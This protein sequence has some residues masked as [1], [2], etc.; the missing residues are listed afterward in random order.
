VNRPIGIDFLAEGRRPRLGVALL[1]AGALCAAL[2]G[3]RFA[4][5]HTEIASLGDR[6]TAR[7][8]PREDLKRVSL[9][10]SDGDLRRAQAVLDRLSAPWNELFAEIERAV[11]PRVALLGVTPELANGRVTI[12]AEAKSLGEALDFAERL[13]RGQA[14]GD[15]F[16]SSHEV[17][18]QDPHRPVR[19]TLVARWRAAPKPQ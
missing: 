1:A 6:I 7:E 11:G 13:G 2:A 4:A 19:F 14:V 3:W 17:R 9:A 8:R 12:Q 5:L 16:M 10:E 15:A 18:T